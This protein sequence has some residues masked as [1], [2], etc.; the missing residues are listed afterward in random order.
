M[1]EV[2]ARPT[3]VH[4]PA[5]VPPRPITP[6][7]YV[8]PAWLAREHEVL[9]PRVWQ[10]ACL[11]RDVA[12]PGQYVVLNIARES[13]L[14]SCSPDGEIVAHYN[15]CQHRGARV[16]VNERG[17]EKSFTCPYHGWTYRTDGRLIVVP[18]NQRFRGGVD[19][20]ERSLRPVRV[21][22][23]LGMV[24]VCMD[25]DTPP[26]EDYLGPL[27]DR[28]APY[29]LETMTLVGDQTVGL[30]CNWKAVFD[31]FQELYHV[32]HI[33]PQHEL[34]FDCPT[35][36]IDLFANGHTGVTIDGHCVNTRLPIPDEPTPY[37]KR[38]V[39]MF[40]GDPAD[41]AGRVL[42]IR[43][44]V[45]KLRR[46]AGPRLGWDYDTFTDERLSDIE[47]YNLFP[48]TMITVQ[49]DD[50][51]ITRARPHPTDPNWCFWDKFTFHRKPSPEVARRHGVAFEPFDPADV[52]PL[53][54]P[55]HDEFTQEDIIAGR[56][57][58]TITIDQD[59]HYIRDVQ[60]GMHSRGFESQV[61]C[62][63]EVR[64]QHYH[65]WLDHWMGVR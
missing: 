17:C 63:D 16:M 21:G 57:T 13:I 34:M 26:L 5:P 15:V 1:P 39:R 18:D 4:G 53:P 19:R 49:P 40:G 14:V 37:L 29:R 47:Q 42:D 59:V 25:P 28:M 36:L 38:Q 65:D 52:A 24:F 30:G 7:R 44:D 6:E 55:D 10:V 9:W 12:E 54:R 23:A 61:L 35:S 8:S 51:L 33:H 20:N 32:E 11:A 22:V 60:A 3:V 27:V 56:K 50:A 62:E 58:M 48:N 2:H 45:Q 64:I 43:L 41:Y 31:N 46:E